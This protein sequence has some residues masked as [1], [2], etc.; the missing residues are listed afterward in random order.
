MVDEIPA[1]APSGEGDHYF[2]KVRKRRLSTS[3]LTRALAKAADCNERDIG[4]AG[5][6]DSYAVTTQWLSLPC[7]PIAP[8][9]DRIELLEIVKHN[10]KLRMGHSH[11]NRFT[12]R[13]VDVH[14]EAA[15]RMPALIERTTRGLPNYFG[16]Q[17]FGRDARG[18]PQSLRQL[19]AAR[20]RK[21][22]LRFAVS[23]V[24]AV[25][26]NQWLGARVRD[27]L[28]HSA[29]LGDVL[30]K[31]ETGGLFES[32]DPGIDAQRV[33][34]SELDPTGPIYGPKMW[35]PGGVAGEREESI[36]AQAPLSEDEWTKM[37]KWGKGSRR[38]ARIVPQNVECH[39]ED[40]ALTAQFTLPPGAYATT[41]LA[42]WASPTGTSSVGS[43]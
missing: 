24:Q 40:G 28:L 23:V 42:A 21:K 6:K 38:V 15:Q 25:L 36:R 1:Y 12:I 5:R 16:P 2:V 22:E 34:E 10:H 37:A 33:F 35:S 20:A 31:R 7:K 43:T 30:K 39:I 3:Q 27:G 29:V 9:D 26:F 4:A 19:H 17:R 8:D 13:W 18:V 14:P 41:V 32:E 11:G